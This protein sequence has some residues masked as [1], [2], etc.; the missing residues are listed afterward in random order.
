M[1]VRFAAISL[2]MAALFLPAISMGQEQKGDAPT[3][4]KS[5]D[6]FHLDADYHPKT[7]I[8]KHLQFIGPYPGHYQLTSVDTNGIAFS[9]RVVPN[10]GNKGTYHAKLD[11]AL[12]AQIRQMLAQIKVPATPA[13]VEPRQGQLHSAFVFHDG[14]DFFRLNYN[15]PHPAQIDDILAILKK[16]FMATRRA[17]DEEFAAHQKLMRETYGDWQTRADITISAGSQMHACKGNSAVVVLNIGRRETIDATSPLDVSVYHALVLHPAAVVSGSG[18]GGRWSDDPVQSYVAIWTPLKADGFFSADTPQQ[19]LEILH[20]AIDASVTIGGITYKLT[21]GNM[22]VIRLGAD[23]QP[24]VTQL[25]AK[26]EDKA[27]P[28]TTLSRFKSILKN[29]P[30]VQAL[31]WD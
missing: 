9:T 24:T 23:W 8:L 2:L 14:H 22:F 13:V 10:R 29:D 26:F 4:R 20:N 17:Q 27:T 6:W 18:S 16:Q 15:G 1:K 25:G 19:K 28:Q 7:L 21:A 30:A 3:E 31:Q 5:I 11:G 12:L